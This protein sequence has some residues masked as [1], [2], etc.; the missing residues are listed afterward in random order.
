MLKPMEDGADNMLW[1]A[2][3]RGA[4]PRPGAE[5]YLA[6]RGELPV[7]KL[8]AQLPDSGKI[9]AAD[10]I[11][12]LVALY[13]P[14]V[15][16]RHASKLP[17]ALQAQPGLYFR[18]STD[19]GHWIRS[20]RVASSR[21]TSQ[22]SPWSARRHDSSLSARAA[23]ARMIPQPTSQ[24]APAVLRA[25]GLGRLPSSGTGRCRARGTLARLGQRAPYGR[26]QLAGQ[27]W[28]H[29]KRQPAAGRSGFFSMRSRWP[30]ACSMR[31]R[32]RSSRGLAT[33]Q[34]SS[35][36][37]SP[38]Q[39]PVRA[40]RAAAHQPHRS[41]PAKRGARGICKPSCWAESSYAVK[42]QRDDL[43]TAGAQA[44]PVC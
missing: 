34:Q 10:E 20:A 44:S 21:C 39:A 35:M 26:S 16:F 6:L 5:V 9:A 23:E 17:E 12:T 3:I 19:G 41:Q 28:R 14:G 37:I 22:A 38:R 2:D 11:D 13:Q 40:P 15:A 8:I 7:A 32:S 27:C 43:S 24:P 18:L 30:S 1:T 25:S 4:K 42:N 31:Q 33:T 36:A 29:R